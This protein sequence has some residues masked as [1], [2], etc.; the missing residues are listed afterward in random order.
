[1]QCMTLTIDEVLRCEERLQTE[2]VERECVLAAIK[3]LKEHA[4]KGRC[5]TGLDSGVLGLILQG[6][7][8]TKTLLLEAK[9]D[10][11]VPEP[12]PA[13][14]RPKPNIHPELEPFSHGRYGTDTKVVS[15]AIG[16]MTEDFTLKDISKLLKREGSPMHNAAIS[17]VLTRLKR[18]GRIHEI[19][20]GKGPVPSVFR[21]PQSSAGPTSEPDETIVTS[22]QAVT[23][24]AA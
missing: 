24:A 21:T 17:V 11:A 10:S 16:R 7:P 3:V 12:A 8:T 2:I 23:S 9:T 22:E 15:W 5:L 20:C 14:P 1:M 19:K 13:L 6:S 18:N 4:H